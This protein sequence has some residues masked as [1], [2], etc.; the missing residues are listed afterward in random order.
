MSADLSAEASAKEDLSRRSFS[1]VGSFSGRG[2]D[3]L[4]VFCNVRLTALAR[5]WRGPRTLCFWQR[6]TDDA[7]PPSIGR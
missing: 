7:C 1:E 2:G 3:G 6:T 4:S 5:L